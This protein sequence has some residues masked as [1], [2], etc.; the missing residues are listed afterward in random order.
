MLL[1]FNTQLL[2]I[3][4]SDRLHNP[5]I[6]QRYKS[7]RIRHHPPKRSSLCFEQH[8]QQTPSWP[9]LTTA[10]TRRSWHVPSLS[11]RRR[12]ATTPNGSHTEDIDSSS[13]E[14]ASEPR[15]TKRRKSLFHILHLPFSTAIHL[16]YPNIEKIQSK[17]MGTNPILLPRSRRS[18][19]LP[20][21]VLIIALLFQHVISAQGCY[22]ACTRS[23]RHSILCPR[24]FCT[25]R[26]CATSHRFRRWRCVS[27]RGLH[28][29][30]PT[31]ARRTHCRAVCVRRRWRARRGCTRRF[32]RVIRCRV[33]RHGRVSR[34]YACIARGPRR[35]RGQG[36]G[37]SGRGGNR[38]RLRTGKVLSEETQ[39]STETRTPSPSQSSRSPAP[40]TTPNRCEMVCM[41]VSALDVRD[42]CDSSV[43]RVARCR[44]A[45]TDFLGFA[46]IPASSTVSA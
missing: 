5:K 16:L 35:G 34:G 22:S 39:T 4:L 33:R 46:C 30:S 38:G 44:V 23:R 8:A 40:S 17:T 3:V 15:Y 6:W 2:K 14:G 29:R 20:V 26:R 19:F 12:V 36:Y 41:P 10:P 13:Q 1:F 18:H 45:H 27:R 32:C 7:T 21:I 31:K 28:P 25:F 9:L 24:K 37:Q 43:C 42:R 11:R